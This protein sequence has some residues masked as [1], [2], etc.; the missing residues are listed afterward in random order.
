MQ[1]CV[2]ATISYVAADEVR[3]PRVE[4]CGYSAPHPSEWKIHLRI[5][6]YHD[7][8][9]TAPEALQQALDG[10]EKLMLEIKEKYEYSLANDDYERFKSAPEIDW[11]DVRARAALRK[12]QAE[13]TANAAMQED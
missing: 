7:S 4:F 9:Q 11:E 1:K 3:S 12:K 6:M 5:Q 10:L 2:P 13:E 8:P